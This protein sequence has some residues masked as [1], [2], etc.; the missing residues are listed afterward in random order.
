MRACHIPNP[1]ELKVTAEFALNSLLRHA[2]AEANLD[3]ERVQNL[4]EDVRVIEAPLD[5]STLEITLRRNLERKAEAFLESPRDLHALREFREAVA[6]AKSLPLP[7]VLWSVQNR[8]WEILQKIY[9][10]MKE[11]GQSEWTAEFEQLAHMLS[12]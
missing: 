6:I 3:L 4:L 1:K 7:L 8:C 9:P 2:F 5:Q 11:R 10:E 12:L